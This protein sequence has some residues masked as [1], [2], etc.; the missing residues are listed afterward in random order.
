MSSGEGRLVWQEYVV[1]GSSVSKADGAEGKSFQRVAWIDLVAGEA[2]QVW[3]RE[4]LRLRKGRGRHE[5]TVA[6]LEFKSPVLKPAENR[7]P[8]RIATILDR[9]IVAGLGGLTATWLPVHVIFR[10]VKRLMENRLRLVFQ[11]DRCN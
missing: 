8:D 9:T 11:S 5:W 2:N 6:T 10:Q 1:E 4:K 7:K 3:P